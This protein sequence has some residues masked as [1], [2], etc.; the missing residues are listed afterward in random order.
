[1]SGECGMYGEKE[2]CIHSSGSGRPE[3]NGLLEDLGVDGMTL[4]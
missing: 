2:G 3:G 4:K 1:M